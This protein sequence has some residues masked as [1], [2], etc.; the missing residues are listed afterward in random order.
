MKFQRGFSINVVDNGFV[1]TSDKLNDTSTEQTHICN[2]TTN[3]EELMT[4]L[5][6]WLE[7]LN[8]GE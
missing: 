4:Y 2:V 3:P 6:N 1:V 8:A 5:T 7:D